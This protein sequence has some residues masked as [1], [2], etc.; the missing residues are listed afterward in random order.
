MPGPACRSPAPPSPAG[1]YRRRSGCRQRGRRRSAGGRRCWWS[2]APAAARCR[3]WDS[4]R[5]VLSGLGLFAPFDPR[6]AD[7]AL[8][9]LVCG[10]VPAAGPGTGSG[11]AL[12]SLLP[13]PL[14][15]MSSVRLQ[16]PRS[17]ARAA[18]TR[19]P[20][21]PPQ[22][23]HEQL[24]RFI[25]SPTPVPVVLPAVRR[26]VRKPQG[27]PSKKDHRGSGY[28]RSTGSGHEIA[29]PGRTIPCYGTNRRAVT[30]ACRRIHAAPG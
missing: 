7:P 8:V 28:D 18:A 25:S 24:E 19:P 15:K 26:Y 11:V 27:L 21:S 12:G 4:F 23:L 30:A 6:L 3:D 29:G 10:V 5:P 20:R 16:P 13:G 9:W 22:R 17:E 1:R 14:P 2:S